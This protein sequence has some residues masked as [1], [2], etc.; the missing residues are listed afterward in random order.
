[1]FAGLDAIGPRVRKIIVSVFPTLLEPGTA[2]VATADF[3]GLPADAA[4]GARRGDAERLDGCGGSNGR[5][6]CVGHWRRFAGL[7]A[8][9]P[10]VTKIVVASI[11]TLIEPSTARKAAT[12]FARYPMHG[13]LVTASP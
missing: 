1:V 6:R 10:R 5:G 12:V 13:A 9:G 3:P 11:T 8:L 2:G 7:H 4:F